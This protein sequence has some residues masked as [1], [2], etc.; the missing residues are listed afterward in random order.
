MAKASKLPT[1][2]FTAEIDKFENTNL[3]HFHIHVPRK[4]AEK[5]IDGNDRRIVC[6]LNKTE[7]FQAA[8]MPSGKGD[9][10]I[11]VNKKLRDRLKLRDADEVFVELEKDTSE[12]G[13]PMPEEF[14]ELMDQDYAGKEHF[15]ALTDG[16]K[17]TLLYII[18]KPKSPDL[19]IRNG[20]AVLEHLKR[21]EGQVNYKQLNTDIKNTY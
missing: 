14:A 6:T 20:I 9:F 7:T 18:G 3:W 21:N 5:F 1:T 8:L 13:L 16:K 12:F 2:S 15:M 11:L 17:R 10:F 4:T 19:R